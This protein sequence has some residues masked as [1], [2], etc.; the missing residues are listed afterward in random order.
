V[1]ADVIF[2]SF[3]LA[4][5]TTIGK[6]ASET[7]QLLFMLDGFVLMPA[8]LVFNKFA[9]N[10]DADMFSHV[11]ESSSSSVVYVMVIATIVFILRPFVAAELH[12][13]F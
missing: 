4:D 12:M 13:T 5:F 1:A 7:R 10:A 9:L 6:T 3:I 11:M 2:D 8:L